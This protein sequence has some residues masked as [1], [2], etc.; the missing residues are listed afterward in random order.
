ML[1]EIIMLQIKLIIESKNSIQVEAT[2]LIF[3]QNEI[4][5]ESLQ[6]L[7]D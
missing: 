5:Q 2:S 7:D 4:E 3:E 1:F 6:I